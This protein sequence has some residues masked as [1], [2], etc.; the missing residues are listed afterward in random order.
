MLCL[1]RGDGQSLAEYSFILLM[2]ALVVF[3]ILMI[4][5]PQVG[6]MYS[7]ITNGVMAG[8]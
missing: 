8:G 2:V 1:S 6:N 7:R 5:G 4:L 3:A